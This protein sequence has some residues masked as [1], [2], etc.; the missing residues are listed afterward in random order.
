[1]SSGVEAGLGWDQGG[2]GRQALWRRE[3]TFSASS[4]AILALFHGIAF[5]YVRSTW[6]GTLCRTAAECYVS[7][8]TKLNFMAGHVGLLLVMGPRPWK[9]HGTHM[10]FDSSRCWLTLGIATPACPMPDTASKSGRGVLLQTGNHGRRGSLWLTVPVHV[11]YIVMSFEPL[12][13]LSAVNCL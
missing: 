1:M 6:D 7:V 9:L 11:L 13:R 2:E 3:T 8:A 10:Q 5:F 12:T 4:S